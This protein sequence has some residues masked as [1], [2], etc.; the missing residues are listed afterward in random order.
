M[1]EAEAAGG[2]RVVDGN[3]LET[4][5]Y[6]GYRQRNCGC[7]PK[8]Y[9]SGGFKTVQE[10]IDGSESPKVDGDVV[11]DMVQGLL[12]FGR[13]SDSNRSLSR[14]KA[15]LWANKKI[16]ITVPYPLNDPKSPTARLYGK[17][18]TYPPPYTQA[19]S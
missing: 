18:T 8:W 12:I 1:F 13:D 9:R 15:R 14:S 6:S 10:T 3:I 7:L 2:R 17:I 4:T 11:E 19:V 5:N 16:S